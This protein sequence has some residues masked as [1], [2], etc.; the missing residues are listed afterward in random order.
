MQDIR[1]AGIS[2][3]DTDLMLLEEFVSSPAFSEFFVQRTGVCRKC[4]LLDAARS[5]TSANGESDLEVMVESQ[6]GERILL[7]VENKVNAGFQPNQASRYRERGQAYVQNGK[8]DSFFT[9]LVAPERYFPGDTKDFDARLNYEEIRDFIV[10]SQLSE[11]RKRYKTALLTGA[12]EKSSSG[13][14]MIADAAVSDFWLDYWRLSLE[15]APELR[16]DR[17]DNKPAGAGFVYFYQAGLP[18]GA[19]LVHK[20]PHGFF[21]LQFAS[22][23]SKLKEMHQAFDKRLQAGMTIEKAAKSASIRLQ[24]PALS[25]ADPLERQ[26]DAA[27]Q[28]FEAGKRLLDW[29]KSKIDDAAL[30]VLLD[31]P[32]D[33]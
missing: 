17:P 30:S 20:L 11:G 24:V 7:L 29:G 4:R 21:D 10:G 16:L 33:Q 27:I 22:M 13:Y 32:A 12:I 8:A 15:V 23:G 14:Q 3:R 18:K 5:V 26:R 31:A 9:V 1:I 25:T 19:V 6:D 2:E 28:G